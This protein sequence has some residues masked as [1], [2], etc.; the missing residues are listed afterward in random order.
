MNS[1]FN[2]RHDWNSLMTDNYDI[3][4]SNY[5]T[6]LFPDASSYVKYLNEYKDL[7][8]LNIKFNTTVRK[9]FKENDT[10]KLNIGNNDEITCEKL[11]IATGFNSTVIPNMIPGIEHA[12]DYSEMSVDQK[13]TTTNEF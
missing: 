5:D 4:L 9:I 12:V 2:M 7:T 6:Q 3:K 10:F 11:I 1:E 8:D 13:N